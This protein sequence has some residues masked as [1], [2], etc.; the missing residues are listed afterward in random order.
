MAKYRRKRGDPVEAYQWHPDLYPADDSDDLPPAG[1]LR[2][3]DPSGGWRYF[4]ITAHCQRVYLALGDWILPEP[5]GVGYYPI[6]AHFF[7]DTYEKVED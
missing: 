1:V 4:V 5:G 3:E 2:E 7:K 6:K